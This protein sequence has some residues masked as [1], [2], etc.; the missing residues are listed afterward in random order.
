[1][2]ASRIL[3]DYALVRGIKLHYYRI[4]GGRVPLVFVHGITDDGLCWIPVI[5]ALPEKY[6]AVLV[7]LRGHGKSDDPDAGYTL[8]NLALDLEA[9]IRVL[10]LKAPILLGHSLGAI[11][12]L[13]VAGMTPEIPRGIILEDPPPFWNPGFSSGG[14]EGIGSS[15]RKWITGVKRKTREELIAEERAENPRWSGEELELLADAKQRFSPAIL[16]LIGPQ[17]LGSVDIPKI[18]RGITCPVE[19]LSADRQLGAASSAVD[20]AL[21]KEWIPQLNDT[22]I[23][24]AGHSI[25][26]DQFAKYMEALQ[27]A[28]DRYDADL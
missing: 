5:R 19:F 27:G 21:L 18:A 28:L 11:V 22:R 1:M 9:M 14:N 26:R 23:A 12:S 25:H 15:M 16:R 4:R 6:D 2:D 24:G 17:S 3:A 8:E 10:Q 13:L 7:D 20:I